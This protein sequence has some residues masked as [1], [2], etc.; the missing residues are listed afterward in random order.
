M[1]IVLYIVHQ[2]RKFSDK[3]KYSSSEFFLPWFKQSWVLEDQKKLVWSEKLK[4]P[5]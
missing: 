2:Y 3:T 1:L 4:P 5:K